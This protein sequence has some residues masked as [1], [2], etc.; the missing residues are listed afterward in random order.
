MFQISAAVLHTWIAAL[1]TVVTLASS[2]TAIH[3]QI[4]L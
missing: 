4:T 2:A 1:L 3:R